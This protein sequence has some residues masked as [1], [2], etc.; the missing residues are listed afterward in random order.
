MA[1][2]V[3]FNPGRT[4]TEEPGKL[5]RKNAVLLPES[6][7]MHRIGLQLAAPTAVIKAQRPTSSIRV[8]NVRS[9]MPTIKFKD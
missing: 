9:K 1:K 3:N 5:Y 8:P 4:S 2:N 7:S 6:A